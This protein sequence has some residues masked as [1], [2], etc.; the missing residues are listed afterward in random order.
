MEPS[1]SPLNDI[2]STSLKRVQN[3]YPHC[4]SSIRF[5][6]QCVR[7]FKLS[8]VPYIKITFAVVRSFCVKQLPKRFCPNADPVHT[9]GICQGL[10]L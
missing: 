9:T 2:Q 6:D 7:A 3:V 10:L 8:Q 5:A 4:P 1:V